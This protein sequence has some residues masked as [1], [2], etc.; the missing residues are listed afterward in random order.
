MPVDHRVVAA[1]SHWRPHTQRAGGKNVDDVDG[2]AVRT[3]RRAECSAVGAEAR[4][5]D[6]NDNP[7]WDSHL[8]SAAGG[9]NRPSSGDADD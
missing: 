2:R 4:H 5:D 1:N 7:A 3:V 8:P 6:D 9:F